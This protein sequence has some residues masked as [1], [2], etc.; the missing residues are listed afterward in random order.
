MFVVIVIRDNTEV[1]SDA[2]VALLVIASSVA[3]FL[4][5]ETA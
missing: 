5:L 3:K 1:L 2:V 4:A